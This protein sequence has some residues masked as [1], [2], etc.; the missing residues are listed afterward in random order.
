MMVVPGASTTIFLN[1][2]GVQVSQFKE[3]E[4]GGHAENAFHRREHS[5]APDRIDYPVDKGQLTALESG[6]RRYVPV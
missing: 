6:H 4:L 5:P 1:M 3:L 2:F